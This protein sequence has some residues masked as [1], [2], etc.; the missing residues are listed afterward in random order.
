MCQWKE[1]EMQFY[2]KL[3]E[4]KILYQ[5]CISDTITGQTIKQVLGSGRGSF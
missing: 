1:D 4:D 5:T 3:T 2:L